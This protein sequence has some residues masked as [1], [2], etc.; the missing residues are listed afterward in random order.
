MVSEHEKTV[1]KTSEK[2]ECFIVFESLDTLI[3]TNMRTSCL[4]LITKEKFKAKVDLI[5]G[6]FFVMVW[7]QYV[8]DFFVFCHELLI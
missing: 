4:Y 8:T 2:S 1:S 7:R 6:G 5:C 3:N